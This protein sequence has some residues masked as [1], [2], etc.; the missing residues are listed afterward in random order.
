[1]LDGIKSSARQN[2]DGF[3]LVKFYSDLTMPLFLFSVPELMI[4][5][6]IL[7]AE[8]CKFAQVLILLP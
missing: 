4:E 2:L 3:L 1:M 6:G 5:L 7:K 8:Y